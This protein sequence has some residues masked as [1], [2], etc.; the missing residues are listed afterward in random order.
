ML[1]LLSGNTRQSEATLTTTAPP[2]LVRHTHRFTLSFGSYGISTWISTL[3]EDVG[4][5]NAYAAAFIYALAN[6]PGNAASIL[7][8]EKYGRR[9]MLVSVEGCPLV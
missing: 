1:S 5:T 4:L 9:N 7:Y 3:F 8:I 2:P 6:L